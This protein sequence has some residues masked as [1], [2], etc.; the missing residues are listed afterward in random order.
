MTT[1]VTTPTS[2]GAPVIRLDG[3]GNL[4]TG[5]GLATKDAR[6]SSNF[7]ARTPRTR[8]EADAL[9]EQDDIYPRIVDLI[10][11]HGTRRWLQVTGAMDERGRPARDFS[12]Q[13]HEELERLDAQTKFFDL[14]RLHRHCGAVMIVGA[15]D[16]QPPNQPLDLERL[17]EV[18]FLNVVTPREV[19]VDSVDPDV[20]SENF[21][22]PEFYRPTSADPR[23]GGDMLIHHSRVIRLPKHLSV[24]ERNV[25]VRTGWDG[26]VIERVWEPL[27]QFNAFFAHL[28][29]ALPALIQHVYKMK[30]LAEVATL[31]DADTAI[32]TR[33][34]TIALI[35]SQL[36][37]TIVDAADEEYTT[38]F[39]SLPGLEAGPRIFDRLSAA[40]GIPL[41]I[42]FGQPPAG[43]STDDES[44]RKAFY[45]DVATDQRRLLRKAV[46]YLITLL[47]RAKRGLLKGEEPFNWSFSFLP[48]EE[49]NDNEAAETAFIRAQTEALLIERGTLSPEE[50]RSR[51]VNDPNSPY[52][53]DLEDD[54][55]ELDTSELTDEEIAAIGRTSGAAG[56]ATGA[57]GLN[58]QQQIPNGSQ[59]ASGVEIVKL[60]AQRA[61]PVDAAQ[62]LLAVAFGKPADEARA[63]LGSAGTTFFAADPAAQPPASEED[64]AQDGDE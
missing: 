29:Q 26:T 4:L 6:E 23:T 43:L 8:E 63:L 9:Y 2:E 41:S 34:Q 59:M 25:A 13:V 57:G 10:P 44:G 19:T 31:K 27:R 11:K 36:S 7:Y 24:N 18:R 21:G 28:E 40:T 53:L 62:N 37:T 54:T 14:W 49:P 50:V 39:G 15:N 16:G 35:R 20:T 61:I 3:W 60:A 33:L 55:E 58:V 5:I 42:L 52:Q 17:Q 12:R 22:Q 51:Y 30:G 38:N 45:A 64:D 32:V 47:I 56:M 1:P 48:L 46:T